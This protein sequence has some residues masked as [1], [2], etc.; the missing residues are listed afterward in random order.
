MSEWSIKKLICIDDTY[1]MW[2]VTGF[3][4][5]SSRL[6]LTTTTIVLEL[7]VVYHRISSFEFPPIVDNN[8]CVGMNL[9][10]FVSMIKL[11]D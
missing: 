2:Y 3:A 8:R 9:D 10:P 7:Y 11:W 1:Y 6:L 5:S 4:H